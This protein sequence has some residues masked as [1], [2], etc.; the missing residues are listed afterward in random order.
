MPKSRECGQIV[1][2]PSLLLSFHSNDSISQIP[3]KFVNLVDHSVASEV[4]VDSLSGFEPA[5]NAPGYSG[6]NP[7]LSSVL[8]RYLLGVPIRNMFLMPYWPF[9]F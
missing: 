4:V 2:I 1:H 3:Y 7:V 6:L 9:L 8:A 5:L